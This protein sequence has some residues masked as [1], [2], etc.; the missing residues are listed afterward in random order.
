[1]RLVLAYVAG[2]LTFPLVL[3]ALAMCVDERRWD[4]W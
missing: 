3:F 2:A 1:M 4:Q